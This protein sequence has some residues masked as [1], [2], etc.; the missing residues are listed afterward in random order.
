[1]KNLVLIISTISVLL[2]NQILVTTYASD[3]SI[4]GNEQVV[5]YSDEDLRLMS[6]II[7]C[8]AG[9]QCYAGQEAVGI[10]VMNRVESDQF[11][12]NIYDVIYQ[13]GQFTP[14]STDF[15]K[16]GL[17]MYD[18]NEIPE[19]CVNAAM[20]ALD[21]ENYVNYEEEILDLSECL[22][23]SRYVKN[24]KFEIQDHEFK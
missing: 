3:T 9:N 15:L 6:A 16:K 14:A 1:M 5:A 11:P 21:G 22:F 24:A 12:N 8:E 19:S 10:V 2:S 4:G 13:K 23:F 18:N 17:K 20:A 7:F